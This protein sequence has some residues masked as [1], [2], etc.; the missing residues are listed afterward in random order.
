MSP[1]IEREA[2]PFGEERA[3]KKV[4]GPK[5]SVVRVVALAPRVRARN[6]ARR[7]DRPGSWLAR[8]LPE[9][10][11]R[12]AERALS[13][14]T[15]GCLKRIGQKRKRPAIVGGDN[16]MAAGLSTRAISPNAPS[17]VSSHSLTPIMNTRFER[18]ASERQ[19]IGGRDLSVESLGEIFGA[20]A[21]ERSLD[22]LRHHIRRLDG[23]TAAQKRDRAE[24]GPAAK[25]SA[26]HFP[27]SASRSTSPSAAASRS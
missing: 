12:G 15:S 21:G 3:V 16:Q 6:R 22:H 10:M 24:P 1:A 9:E 14:T 8:P 19:R 18:G 25:V 2:E 26:A 27:S 11:D 4:K 23:K 7:A 13:G 17:S 20:C 5:P